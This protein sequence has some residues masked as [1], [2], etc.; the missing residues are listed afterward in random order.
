M[1]TKMSDGATSKVYVYHTAH[2]LVKVRFL[3]VSQSTHTMD[4]KEASSSL[5]L[6]C[7]HLSN[8]SALSF[9]FL[10]QGSLSPLAFWDILWPRG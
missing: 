9:A 2:V 5:S 3:R 1:A 8:L 6:S 10:S 7:L 4:L